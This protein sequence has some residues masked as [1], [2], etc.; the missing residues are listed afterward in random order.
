M[1]A[2]REPPQSVKRPMFFKVCHHHH[3]HGRHRHHKRLERLG[4][5]STSL[6]VEKGDGW[7]W[8]MR[9]CLQGRGE[10][11]EQQRCMWSAAD[12][13]AV[14][15]SPGVVSQ[16]AP[17]VST[18]GFTNET[19]AHGWTVAKMAGNMTSSALHFFQLKLN[20]PKLGFILIL[21]YSIL[22]I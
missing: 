5:L 14:L 22:Y 7:W 3:Q 1:C 17:H 11:S 9:C 2:R 8:W 15:W 12:G 6:S 10:A 20:I 19:T 13:G 18:N 4:P 16:C 21:Y